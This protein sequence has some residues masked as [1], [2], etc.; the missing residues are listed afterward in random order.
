[1]KILIAESGSTKTDWVYLA[2]NKEIDFKSIGINPNNQSTETIKSLLIKDVLPHIK[3]FQIEK[4]F[5]YGS[6]CSSKERKQK[7]INILSSTIDKKASIEIEHDLLG[8][9]RAL[10]KNKQTSI[11]CILGT[12]SNSCLFDGQQIKMNIGGHGYILGDEGSGTH[13]GKLLLNAYLNQNLE[14][15]LMEALDRE[16]NLDKISIY[17]AIY[18]NEAPNKFL[19]SFAPFIHLHKDNQSIKELI[20]KAFHDFISNHLVHYPHLDEHEVHFAGSIAY[21]FQDELKL[22]LQAHKIKIGRIVE[23]PIQ[24]LVAYHKK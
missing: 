11:C 21:Y 17:K 14:S 9:S 18:E 5:F 20:T 23:K 3:D 15:D 19:A 7:M 13:L 4:I 8:A 24:Q 1:M 2:D 22:S 12:G 10:C 6:G 16:F